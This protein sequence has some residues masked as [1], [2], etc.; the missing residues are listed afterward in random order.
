MIKDI[1]TKKIIHIKIDEKISNACKKMLEFDIGFLPVSKNSKVIGV[2]TDRDIATK[3][4]SNT[5]NLNV[6]VEDYITRNIISCNINASIED[7]LFIMRKNHV[8]RLLVLDDKKIV[9]IVSLSD[10]IHH[11]KDNNLLIESLK[12]IFAI[13]RNTDEYR[14]EIDEFYL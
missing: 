3:T 1:M 14:T 5:T 9:G 12:E 4:F 7:A 6:K 10:I 2:I 8:K 11:F 13:H